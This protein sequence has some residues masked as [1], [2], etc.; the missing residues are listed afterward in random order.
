MIYI[1][2]S[3]GIDCILPDVLV[4]NVEI[5][6][7]NRNDNYHAQGMICQRMYYYYLKV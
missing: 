1:Y 7:F 6:T 2:Y 4:R 5:K 3:T